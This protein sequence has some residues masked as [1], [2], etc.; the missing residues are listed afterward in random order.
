MQARFD[1]EGNRL[2]DTGHGCGCML[3]A[4]SNAARYERRHQPRDPS[5]GWSSLRRRVVRFV[6]GLGSIR[7]S[8][9]N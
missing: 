2:P 4:A 8:A 7:R 6:V 9:V 1:K 3:C 5:E